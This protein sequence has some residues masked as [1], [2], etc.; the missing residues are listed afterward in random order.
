[1]GT[2]PS[3]DSWEIIVFHAVTSRKCI[4]KKTGDI[5]LISVE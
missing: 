2:A 5:I 3:Y 1:L 4:A